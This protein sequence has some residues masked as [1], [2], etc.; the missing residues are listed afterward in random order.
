M[1]P[2]ASAAV[3]GPC[4]RTI[5]IST[6]ML[7]RLDDDELTAVLAHERAHALRRDP[8]RAAAVRVAARA[9]FDLPLG[10]PSG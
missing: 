2:A 3:P 7:S 9:L 10:L 6:E 4:T 8:A 5:M 1:T